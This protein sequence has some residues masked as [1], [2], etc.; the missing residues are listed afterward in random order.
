M[1]NLPGGIV[2]AE[3]NVYVTGR[4]WDEMDKIM[5][6]LADFVGH[7]YLEQQ[8]TYERAWSVACELINYYDLHAEP[9]QAIDLS[10][11]LAKFD[12]RFLD[13]PDETY[14]FTL[15]SA[16]QI[17]IAL[18]DKLTTE[19]TRFVAAHEVGHIA[20]WHPSPLNN[21]LQNQ[22]L[23]NRLEVEASA[24]AAYLLLPKESISHSLLD[25][26]GN[27]RVAEI[28]ASYA[29]PSELVLVRRVL[30]NQTGY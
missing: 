26:Q 5:L 3:G 9:L 10:P 28:A 24:V 16:H 18:N 30:L 12:L 19:Q 29:V 20:C 8:A 1:D 7:P 4:F 6:I 17:V 11:L 14:G 2:N 15:D 27:S 13:L 22:W 21:C 25:K 23:H